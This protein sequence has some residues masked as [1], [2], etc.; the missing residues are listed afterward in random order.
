VRVIQE[1]IEAKEEGR[2]RAGFP[3]PEPLTQAAR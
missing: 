2:A 3:L 1:V